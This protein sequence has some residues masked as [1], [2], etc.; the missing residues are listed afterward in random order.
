MRLLSGRRIPITARA[1]LLLL[2]GMPCVIL[3]LELAARTLIDFA[4]EYVP[5][6]LAIIRNETIY[7]RKSCRIAKWLRAVSLTPPW[8]VWPTL[9]KRSYRCPCLELADRTKHCLDQ[10]QCLSLVYLI[11]TKMCL[12]PPVRPD[13]KVLLATALIREMPT[14]AKQQPLKIPLAKRSEVGRMIYDRQHQDFIESSSGPWVSLVAS[15][16]KQI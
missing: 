5:I 4:S 8:K 15:V 10:T 6:R 16:K 12:P 14:L 9:Q 2:K 1:V 11:N 13:E 3:F 7:F